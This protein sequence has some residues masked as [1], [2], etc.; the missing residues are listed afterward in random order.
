MQYTDFADTCLIS[1][2]TDGHLSPFMSYYILK[3]IFRLGMQLIGR[4]LGLACTRFKT[5]TLQRDESTGKERERGTG[6]KTHQ[7]LLF[8]QF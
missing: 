7:I 4:I 5:P 1:P 8:L 6:K 2:H 3:L